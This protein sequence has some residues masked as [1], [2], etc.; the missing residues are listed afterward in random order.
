MCREAKILLGVSALF[1]FA[2]ALSGIFVDIFFYRQTNDFIVIVIYNLIHYIVTPI[3][4]IFAGVIAK[5]KN[6][7]WSMRIGLITYALFYSSILFVGNRGIAYIYALGILFGMATGFY[8]LAFNT[9]TF[10]FT[11][12]NNRD[13]FNGFKGSCTGIAAAVAPIT[14]AYIISRFSGFKGYRIVFF[15][16][17]MIYLILLLIS[18]I[19]KC[20]NYGSKVNFKVAFSSKCEQWSIIRK[21]TF[22]LGFRDVVIAFVINILII[23]TT[24][25]ELSLG[26]LTLIA[27]LLSSLAYVLVQRIIKPP[28][29][30]LSINIGAIGTFLAVVGLAINIEY[31]TL[32]IY[33]IMDAFFLPFFMIQLSSSTYNV[34]DRIHQEDMRIEYMI[35]KDLVLNCGRSISAIILIILLSSFKSTNTLKGYLIFIGLAPLVSGYF[36]RK[37]TKVL[38]GVSISKK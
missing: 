37:L 33:I 8:W 30:K 28:H 1:T 23:E 11:C 9:L 38:E 24:G 14:S 36:L 27:S 6:G 17:L 20:E 18:I 2:S 4:F 31:K 26:K 22:I 25:S 12:V 5:R 35:N 29:R 13:T 21:S 3:T 7:I 34:I 32:L 16:T 10:D 19:L 15:M